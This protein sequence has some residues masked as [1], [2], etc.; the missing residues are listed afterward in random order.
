MVIISYYFLKFLLFKK[1]D[2]IEGKRSLVRKGIDYYK[3]EIK[4][5][6]LYFREFQSSPNF[7]IDEN[8]NDNE[9]MEEVEDDDEVEYTNSDDEQPE[10]SDETDIPD[11]NL[12]EMVN[13][14]RQL[15]MQ[16]HYSNCYDN[17]YNAIYLPKDCCQSRLN[18][19]N[20]SNACVII[21]ILMGYGFCD[22]SD[23]MLDCNTLKEL[24]NKLVAIFCGAIDLGNTFYELH[25]LSG[26][27]Q[28]P[29][30]LDLLPP[31]FKLE[32]IDEQ[33]VHSSNDEVPNLQSYVRQMLHHT[34]GHFCII[35]GNGKAVSLYVDRHKII[36]I[37]SHENQA[38]G[39]VFHVLTWDNL[40]DLSSRFGETI[41]Y[42]SLLKCK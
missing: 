19:S 37:D 30:A 17:T 25:K 7:E 3:N 14:G 13:N 20:G 6:L 40:P 34:N 36:I 12:S 35:V 38:F 18:G 21:S 10:V 39:G 9:E 31:S 28:V 15:A 5:A 26:Y 41:L 33:N 42:V 29:E 27:L 22:Q 2:G 23:W 4:K 8:L 24:Y 1:N 32:L 11:I 16:F